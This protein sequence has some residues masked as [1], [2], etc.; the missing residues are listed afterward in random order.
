M[1]RFLKNR[2]IHRLQERIDFQK[3][4]TVTFR[5]ETSTN[6]KLRQFG[7][8]FS[9]KFVWEKNNT[10]NNRIVLKKSDGKN[11]CLD[12]KRLVLTTKCLPFPSFCYNF[13]T[14][15]PQNRGQDI[16]GIAGSRASD[17][18]YYFTLNYANSPFAY[19][20]IDKTTGRIDSSTF[21]TSAWDF[22]YPGMAL[23]DSETHGGEDVA[24]FA[25][26]PW[27]HLFTGTLEQNT[28]PHFM[29]YAACLGDGLTMCSQN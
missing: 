9:N 11:A 14:I 26:G 21:D 19:N 2:S 15:F 7:S 28:L 1:I 22:S 5:L 25:S 3:N 29:A 6:S 17:Q 24:V 4:T 16:L 20:H 27:E 10:Q 12:F 23:V 13:S 18:K 8:K